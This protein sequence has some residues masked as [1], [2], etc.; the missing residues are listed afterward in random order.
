MLRLSIINGAN[1][2]LL[3]VRE[4][5]IYGHET[6]PAFFEA[7]QARFPQIAFSFTQSNIEGELINLLH[8]CRNSADGIILNAGGYSHTSVALGDA[9]AA[10]GMPVVEVHI[11]NVLAREDYRKTSFIAAKCKGSISGLG[12]EGYALAAQYFL[13]TA[14]PH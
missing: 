12:L 9:V 14:K 11:S 7:L 8:A 10:M 3:G 4:T 2:N 5:D 13:S 1:L 6:F